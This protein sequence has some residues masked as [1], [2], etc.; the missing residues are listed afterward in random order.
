MSETDSP[1]GPGRPSLYA[2]KLAEEIVER[3][4]GGEPLAQICRDEHMPAPSTISDWKRAHPAFS[5]SFA[6]GREVGFDAIAARTRQTA[7]GKKED[8]G[9]DSS[10]DVQRDKLIIETDLKLLAKWDPKRYGEKLALTGGS[11][12]D[13]PIRTVRRIE[14]VIVDPDNR[15]AA[16]VPPAPEAEP[17]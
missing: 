14:R 16:G 10:G 4:S 8:E 9:G 1:K 13:S 11:D 17:V 3:L 6:R 5:V 15:D 7:R 2:D 12:E